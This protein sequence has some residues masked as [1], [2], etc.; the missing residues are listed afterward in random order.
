MAGLIERRRNLHRKLSVQQKECENLKKQVS[1]VEPL[2]GVGMISAMTAHEI[3]NLLTPIVNYAQLALNHSDDVNLTKKALEKAKNNAMRASEIMIAMMEMSSAKAQQKKKRIGLS[4]LI[5]QVFTCIGRDFSK[6]CIKVRKNID[7]EITIQADKTTFSHCL[8]NLIINARE[9]MLER[10]GILTIDAAE[11]YDYVAIEICDTGCGIEKENLKDIFEPF[12]T[13]KDPEDP[14][15]QGGAG[16]G[17][18]FCKKA[19]ENH[20]GT[21]S[22]KSTPRTGTSFKITIPK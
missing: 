15:T 18:A 2:A 9:A 10:G 6:D 5:D 7:R 4:E 1:R 21:I 17:L 19:V 14:K 13:T 12:F 22:V 11:D 16:L 8:M 3:N 20:N